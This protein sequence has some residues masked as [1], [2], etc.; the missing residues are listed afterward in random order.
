M[1]YWLKQLARVLLSVLLLLSVFEIILR[2]MGFPQGNFTF[3]EKGVNGAIHPAWSVMRDLWGPIPFI[4]HSNNLGYRGSEEVTADIPPGKFRIAVFGDSFTYGFFCDD[5]DTYPDILQSALEEH[6]LEYSPIVVNFGVPGASIESIL[7]TYK[8][9]S[10]QGISASYTII[11]VSANDV[12]DTK[13]P[14]SRIFPP[15][16]M[17]SESN[18]SE[19][20]KNQL[21]AG[22]VWLLCHSALAEQSL[23]LVLKM[24][25]PQFMAAARKLQ[26]SAEYD[27]YDIPQMYDTANNLKVY[28]EKYGPEVLSTEGPWSETLLAK[29]VAYAQ[30]LQDLV[31]QIRRSGSEP[32]LVHIPS[33]YQVYNPQYT[34][35]LNRELAVMAQNMNVPLFDAS[36][37]LRQHKA[38][39]LYLM[40]LD[41]HMSPAG[42]HVLGKAVAEFLLQQYPVLYSNNS[43]NI[44]KSDHL[45]SQ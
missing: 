13:L 11:S 28:R 2:V 31:A 32:V 38:E 22:T 29:N 37:T 41:M 9:I 25:F 18:L 14:Y 23:T 20:L 35:A 6:A 43:G 42:N 34:G 45:S 33:Y 19:Q 21:L 27:R 8:K 17:A 16:E 4:A 1:R 44:F 15:A 5:E 30:Y 12:K 26:A 24:Q 40:P 7:D 36:E 10:A 39:A 3:A